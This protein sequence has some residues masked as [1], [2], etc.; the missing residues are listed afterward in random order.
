MV[1]L[2]STCAVSMSLGVFSLTFACQTGETWV[3]CC[4]EKIWPDPIKPDSIQTGA[5]QKH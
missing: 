5:D 1:K 2:R 4:F 3:R